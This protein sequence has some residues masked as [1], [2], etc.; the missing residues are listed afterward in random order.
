MIA[1]PYSP[2]SI[3]RAVELHDEGPCEFCDGTGSIKAGP[4]DDDAD[5]CPECDGTGWVE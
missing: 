3:A 4:G 1:D 2:A 5:R